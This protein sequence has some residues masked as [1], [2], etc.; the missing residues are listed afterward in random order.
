MDRLHTAHAHT[1]TLQTDLV[2]G[3]ESSLKSWNREV[4][5]K[6]IVDLQKG[7]VWHGAP[8]L[9]LILMAQEEQ[10]TSADHQLDDAL[11]TFPSPYERSDSLSKRD[12][13]LPAK[14]DS[15]F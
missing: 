3:F 13:A 11:A 4:A 9:E 14:V 5:Q 2:L 12:G 7:I 1:R 10:T 8:Q 15:R 6:G